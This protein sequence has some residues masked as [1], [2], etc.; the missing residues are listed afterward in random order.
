MRHIVITSDRQRAVSSIQLTTFATPAGLM[1]NGFHV[2][3]SGSWVGVYQSYT[4]ARAELESAKT[5]RQR[6]G[7]K[8]ENMH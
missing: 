5:R 2:W 3:D 7:R 1:L 4:R 6:Y 8:E